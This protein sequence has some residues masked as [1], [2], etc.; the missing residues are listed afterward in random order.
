[1]MW[2]REDQTV[3]QSMYLSQLLTSNLGDLSQEQRLALMRG[4]DITGQTEQGEQFTI[5]RR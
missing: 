1:M 2:Y 5:T 4:E 3:G